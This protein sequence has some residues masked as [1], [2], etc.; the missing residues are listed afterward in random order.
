[1]HILTYI[2]EGLTEEEVAL[3]LEMYMRKN[4]AVKIKF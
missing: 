4:G 2:R 1:M 3:E